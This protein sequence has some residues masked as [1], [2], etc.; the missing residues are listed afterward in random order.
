MI[1]VKRKLQN[2]CVE[3][4]SRKL[5]QLNE[6]IKNAQESANSDTKSSM[7]DKYETGRAMAQLEIEKNT[8]QK[9]EIETQLHFLAKIATYNQSEIV[10]QGSL[11]ICNTENFYISVSLGLILLDEIRYFAISTQSPIGQKIKGL[12]RGDKFVVNEKEISILNIF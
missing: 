7:G 1:E 3:R 11:V 12:K 4:L 5:I 9:V 6:D 2:I 10:A 8:I